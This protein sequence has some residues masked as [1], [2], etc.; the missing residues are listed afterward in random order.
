MGQTDGRTNGQAR[1]A[2]SLL[3]RSHNSSFGVDFMKLRNA[4]QAKYTAMT[5]MMM[6]MMITK[7]KVIW[8]KTESLICH[9]YAG[10]GL[11]V[12]LQFEIAVSAGGSS[13]LIFSF[14]S[15]RVPYLAQCVTGSTSCT[16]HVTSKC[17]GRFKQ[18]RM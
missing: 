10:I 4:C 1:R 12:W 8:Q 6:M 5:T 16:W 14:P 9:N 11:A 17:I 13:P 7:F 18:P 15:V 2:M 3:F